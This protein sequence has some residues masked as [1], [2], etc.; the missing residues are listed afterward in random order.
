MET[1]ELVAHLQAELGIQ[2]TQ[3]LI[4]EQHRGLRGQGTGDGHTLL[5]AAGELRR[6]AVHE[7]A[8]LHD[9]GHPADGEV[10]LLLGELPGLHDHLSVLEHLKRL[11]Q[12]LGLPGGGDL[13]LQG[14]NLTG[15]VL[16]LLHVVAVEALGGVEGDGEGVD[17]LDVGLLLVDFSRLVP[18]VLQD[19]HHL[20]GGL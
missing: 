1:L 14:G 4:H 20:G 3:R 6:V 10:D 11:V 7:H 13:G 12:G 8:D 18:A 17:E 5:L 16:V 15:E 19:L 9:P 2:V